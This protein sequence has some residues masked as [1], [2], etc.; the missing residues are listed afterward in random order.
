MALSAFT[1]AQC[2]SVAEQQSGA[3]NRARSKGAPLYCDRA[4][5]GLARR[6]PPR[7]ADERKAEKRAYDQQYRTANRDILKAKKHAAYVA[8]YDPEQAREYR[9]T[10]MQWHVEYCRRRMADPEYRKA[11]RKYDQNYRAIRTY[12]PAAECFVALIQLEREIRNRQDG[13]T[14]RQANGT[15]NKHQE[16]RRSDARLVGRRYE[17]NA[18]GNSERD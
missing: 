18:M 9:K 5:A 7:T 11:K 15:L 2:G 13:Y 16:R 8:S 3:I 14:I 12:G 4:C 10:R 17:T 1:C 6:K